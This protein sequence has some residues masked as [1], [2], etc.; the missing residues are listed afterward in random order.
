MKSELGE[1]SE[2]I[3][4]IPL[5]QVNNEAFDEVALTLYDNG[6]RRDRYK[7]ELSDIY[8]HKKK[9]KLCLYFFTRFG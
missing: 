9:Y 1:G 5:A 6:R 7:I 4:K 8:S 3:I 2:F